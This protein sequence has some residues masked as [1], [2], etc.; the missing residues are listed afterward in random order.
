LDEQ[1]VSCN[2]NHVVATASWSAPSHG[3]LWRES[4]S[5][6]D[7][8]ALRSA[9]R[10]PY[11]AVCETALP[12]LAEVFRL[13]EVRCPLEQA[14]NQELPF[15]DRSDLVLAGKVRISVWGMRRPGFSPFHSGLSFSVGQ[16]R[17]LWARSSFRVREGVPGM[18]LRR[19][20]VVRDDEALSLWDQAISFFFFQI[21]TARGKSPSGNP[22]NRRIA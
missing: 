5:E 16:G 22:P 20:R 10:M 3:A 17:R 1:N 14:K 13:M 18:S 7:R 8:F 9:L 2:W 6:T 19:Y 11:K 4:C 12:Q 15:S 21:R